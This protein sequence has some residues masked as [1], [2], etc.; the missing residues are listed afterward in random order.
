MTVDSDTAPGLR[1]V[2]RDALTPWRTR[3]PSFPVEDVTTDVVA[4]LTVSHGAPPNHASG[5][6]G[7]AQADIVDQL[8]G[9]R[10]IRDVETQM[11]NG[12]TLIV[13]SEIKHPRMLAEAAGEI[14]RL[15]A[16][17]KQAHT[18]AASHEPGSR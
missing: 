14:V 5:A 2:I 9:V 8:L 1:A 16:E 3:I 7:A 10:G 4:A 11:R 12:N 6:T 18:A 13:R 15:R 17:L